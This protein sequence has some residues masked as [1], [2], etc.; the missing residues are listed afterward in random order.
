LVLRARNQSI[1]HKKTRENQYKNVFRV[2]G[3]GEARAKEAKRERDQENPK[4]ERGSGEEILVLRR[5]S[6]RN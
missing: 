6:Q 1:L 2:E 5:R 3:A 4:R